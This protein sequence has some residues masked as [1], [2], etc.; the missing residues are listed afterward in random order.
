MRNADL[1]AETTLDLV[2]ICLAHG[3]SPSDPLIVRARR[4]A[5]EILE[6]LPQAQPFSQLGGFRAD[7]PGERYR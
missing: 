5:A 3:I 6:A 7:D 1:L 4:L 2:T